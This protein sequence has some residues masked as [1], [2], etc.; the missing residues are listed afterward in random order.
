M[1]GEYAIKIEENDSQLKFLIESK[2][3]QK[4]IEVSV[5]GKRL[6]LDATHEL[7]SSTDIKNNIEDYAHDR[8]PIELPCEV[9]LKSLELLIGENQVSVSNYPRNAYQSLHDDILKIKTGSELLTIPNI[10][11][12]PNRLKLKTLNI[13]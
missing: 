4:E 6:Y 2:N 10:T 12:V 8:P 3:L 13:K 11:A 1:N 9:V 5:N 7:Q